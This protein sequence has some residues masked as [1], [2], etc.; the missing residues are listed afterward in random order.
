MDHGH[1]RVKQPAVPACRRAWAMSVV[2][3]ES[4]DA[5]WFRD[6]LTGARGAASR[7]GRI[8]L[9]KHRAGEVALAMSEAASNLVKHAVDGAI[10][11]RIADRAARRG[12]IPGRG[13]RTGDDGRGR[14]DV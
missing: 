12:R 10:L 13:Q 8:G 7:L 9:S 11:L 4:E 1:T 6:E 5:A 3:L 2:L 14:F